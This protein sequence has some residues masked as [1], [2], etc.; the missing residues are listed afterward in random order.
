MSKLFTLK[1]WLNVPDAAQYLSKAMN[2]VVTEAD[3]FRL[4]VDGCISL[5]IYFANQTC[6]VGNYSMTN[7]DANNLSW[8]LVEGAQHEGVGGIEP[9]CHIFP[10][11][12]P[13]FGIER[14]VDFPL[15][16]NE[17]LLQHE[18]FKRAG[19]PEIIE[20]GCEGIFV[21]LD[22]LFPDGFY[23]KSEEKVVHLEGRPLLR[24][25]ELTTGKIKTSHEL[26]SDSFFA[27]R[28]TALTKFLQSLDCDQPI[29]DRPLA[30]T[31]RN[32]LLIIIAALCKKAG[33]DP[34][35]RDAASD[36][37]RLAD[38]VGVKLD[39]GTVRSKLKQIPDAIA[40]RG[41]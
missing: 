36:V 25:A 30:P 7:I 14:L 16:G 26:P 29:I 31:E 12:R 13:M 24:L 21:I 34:S 2:E 4:A 18:Y 28:T 5:S 20:A 17:R 3:I 39:D 27:L 32:T 9:G 23:E 38:A 11:K 15:I 41:R 33:L 8:A 40:A 22:S 35:A 19:G 10:I 6:A 1:E 37:V